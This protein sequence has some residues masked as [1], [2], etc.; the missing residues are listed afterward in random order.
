MAIRIMY[1]VFLKIK[2]KNEIFRF[3]KEYSTAV[4]LEY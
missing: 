1:Y 3:F 2:G 4:T